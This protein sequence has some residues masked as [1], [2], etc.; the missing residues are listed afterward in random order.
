MIIRPIVQA[1]SE[2]LR[3]IAGRPLRPL[4]RRIRKVLEDD[5]PPSEI[6]DTHRRGCR[7]ITKASPG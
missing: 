3:R 7:P 6:A 1:R 4:T 2:Y 5:H